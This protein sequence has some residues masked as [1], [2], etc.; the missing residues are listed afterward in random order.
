MAQQIADPLHDGKT[1]AK[2]AAALARGVVELTKF[3]EDRFQLCRGDAYTRVPHLDA[4]P[5]AASAAA[6]QHLS[7]FGIFHRVRKEVAEHLLQQA[8]IA[9]HVEPARDH[10]PTELLRYSVVGKLGSEAIEHGADLKLYDF[11]TDDPR[12]ELVDVEQRIQHAG[13]RAER[14][15]ELGDQPGAIMVLDP[16][17]QYPPQQAERL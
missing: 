1:Q 13:H 3:L 2:T 14:F 9:A 16:L 5:V 15:L 8:W 12:L 4:Q 6:K 11:R 10:A 7:P 17:A